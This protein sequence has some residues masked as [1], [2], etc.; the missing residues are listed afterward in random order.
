MTTTHLRLSQKSSSAPNPSILKPK[1]KSVQTDSP[2][3]PLIQ[4]QRTLGNQAIQ[5]LLS[6]NVLQAKLKIGQPNDIYEQ[7]A[8]R[9]ADLV[10]RMSDPRLQRQ[11]EPEEE[12]T[13]QAKPLADQITPL[14]QKQVP[15]EEEEGE[16]EPIQ[17]EH[18]SGRT[19]QVCP[20]LAAQIRSLRGGGRPLPRSVRSFFEPR[21]GH[22]FSRVRVHTHSQAAEAARTVSAIAFTA[23][24]DIIFGA[25]QY[26]PETSSGRRLV[27][28]ELTHV[29]QQA[30]QPNPALDRLVLDSSNVHKGEADALAR[31]TVLQA[32]AGATAAGSHGKT[33]VKNHIQRKPTF[34][35]DC[36][37]WHRCEVIEPL[38]LAQKM[39]KEVQKELVPIASGKVTTGRIIDLLNVHFHT[40][41]ALIKNIPGNSPTE[42]HMR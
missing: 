20:G 37:E 6:T 22:I 11:V 10:M 42:P 27:A 7:E 25:G 38:G 19:P 21:F 1:S 15:P 26:A 2:Q 33:A 35:K 34:S 41:T 5:R 12:E 31:R 17:A 29:L 14:V 32:E 4:L 30:Q 40:S 18:A 28:H 9:V 39:V 8:D 36:T 3:L 24:E 16:E 13:L 23:G